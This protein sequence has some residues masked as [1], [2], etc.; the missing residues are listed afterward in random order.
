MI[1]KDKELEDGKELQKNILRE[2]ETPVVFHN[3]S[4]GIVNFGGDFYEAA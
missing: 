2:K 4:L 3:V 1:K